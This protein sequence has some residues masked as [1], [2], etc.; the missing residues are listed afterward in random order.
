MQ[1]G[2]HCGVRANRHPDTLSDSEVV[3]IDTETT[4][5]DDGAEVIEIAALRLRE[6]RIVDRY[7]SV[8]RPTVPIQPAATAVHG[9]TNDD[10]ANAPPRA[11]VMAWLGDFLNDDDVLAAHYAE[12][13]RARLP[14]L[15]SH[16]WLCTWRLAR[17]LWPSGP[18]S[19]S[20]G[21]LAAWLRLDLRW[22]KPTGGPHRAAY[23]ATVTVG[24]LHRELIAYQGLHPYATLDDVVN[25]AASPVQVTVL[26]YGR[27]YSG[28]PI[29]EI[30][31]P[32]L[33]WLVADQAKPKEQRAIPH[34]DADTASALRREL[35]SRKKDAAA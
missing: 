26:N 20:N 7:V 18:D 3:I 2:S 23:D 4:G 33:E 16:R 35:E 29:A 25:Y 9:F 24:L 12:F 1:N 17:H 11:V 32:Y 21:A 15:A 34:M 31:L 30:D 10:L 6:G 22:P 13:D 5:K 19:Y 27:K 14:L 8:I 28:S